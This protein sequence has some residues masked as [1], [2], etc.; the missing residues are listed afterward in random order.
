MTGCNEAMP[1]VPMPLTSPAIP[2]PPPG[3]GTLT[4]SVADPEGRPLVD[5]TVSVFNPAQAQVVG[6]TRTGTTG[7]A[8]VGSV[9]AT[10]LVYVHHAFGESYRNGNVDVA[11]QGVTLLSV[12]LQPGRPMPTVALLPVS[13]PADSIGEDRSELA[14]HIKVVAS[15]SAPFVPAGYGDYSVASTPALGLAL[16]ARD[17]AGSSYSCL[18]WLDTRRTVPACGGPWGESPYTVSVEEF[19]YDRAGTVP[20][21]A[22]PGPARSAM[23]IMDQSARVS[24]LDPGVRRS[25]AARQFIA[26]TLAPSN[27]KSLSVAGLAG[28]GGNAS[29]PVSLPEQPLW[30]PLAPGTLF[31]TD[32]AV[33]DAAVAVLEPMVG[34][35]AP[36]F[37]GLEAAFK[38]SATEAPPGSRAVVAL[39]GGSDDRDM[40]ESERRAALAALRRQ[41]DDTGIQTVLIAAAPAIAYREHE[42]LAELAAALRAPAV[43][44]GVTEDSAGF[45]GQAWAAG[46]FAALD[47]AANLIDAVPLPTLSAVF[48]IRASTANAFPAGATLYGVAYVE[49]DICPMGC[50]EIPL[51]FAAE[52]P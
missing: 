51:V 5:A 40:S 6:S 11:Q 33:L 49:S 47:L 25:F 37:D 7:V 21:L 43:S 3:T 39:I 20:L 18:V 31:S 13:I 36:V 52:I 29:A 1:P 23:L 19:S 17:S 24:G 14:L 16:G 48:R 42:A 30:L 34:G 10:A 32:R 15:G 26:R 45:Y 35:S 12:T 50:W 41:R 44:L 27:P 2:V 4:V 28:D 22:S 38:L 46:S 8:T 9:P